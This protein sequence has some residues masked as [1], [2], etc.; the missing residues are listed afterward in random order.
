MEKT[1][2]GPRPGRLCLGVRGVLPAGGE[3]RQAAEK[4][5]KITV[6]LTAEEEKNGHHN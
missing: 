1:S 4:R 5:E 2:P 6:N 3:A